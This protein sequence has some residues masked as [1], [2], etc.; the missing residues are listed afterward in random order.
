MK[1]LIGKIKGTDYK[2]LMIQHG[3]KI[4]LGL[5]VLVAVLVCARGYWFGYDKQP[6]ELEELAVKAKATIENSVFPEEE[7]NKFQASTYYAKAEQMLRPLEGVPYLY[8]TQFT[9]S[10]RPR[11]ERNKEPEFSTVEHLIAAYGK[12]LM[13]SNEPAPVAEETEEMSEDA[14]EAG[15]ETSRRDTT[16]RRGS[17]TAG[18]AMGSGPTAAMRSGRMPPPGEITISGISGEG[19]QSAEEVKPNVEGRQFISVRGVFPLNKQAQRYMRALHTDNLL[20][21]ADLVEIVD[22]K[23]QRQKIVPGDKP[24]SGPWE[25]L[26]YTTSI[27]VLDAAGDIDDD[28]VDSGVLDNTISMPLPLRLLGFWTDTLASHP[29]LKN[30]ELSKEEIEEERKRN[31]MYM[32]QYNNMEDAGADDPRAKRGFASRMVDIRGIRNAV[33]QNPE[34]SRAMYSGA[35]SAGGRRPQMPQSSTMPMPAPVAI[36]PAGGGGH[37]G[38]GARP[39]GGMRNMGMGAM[40]AMAGGQSAAEAR[41]AAAGRLLLFRYLDFDVE[42][43]EAYRYRVR[44]EFANPNYELALDQVE[45]EDIAEGKTRW[46]DWSEPCQAVVVEKEYDFFLTDVDRGRGRALP[47]AR[48]A[49]FQWLRDVGSYINTTA[50]QPLVVGVGAYVGGKGKSTLLEPAIPS[51]K[52]DQTVSFTSKD[53][54]VDVAPSPQVLIGEHPDLQLTSK[55]ATR[56]VRV[57]PDEAVVVNQFGEMVTIDDLSGRKQEKKAEAMVDRERKDFEDLLDSEKAEGS[58]LDR[59]TQMMSSEQP[60]NKKKKKDKSPLMRGGPGSMMP[61][62]PP[63]AA[64]AGSG[65]KPRR[66]GS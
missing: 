20:E 21:A 11:L 45:R 7:K 43:G 42:P 66:G 40:G 51:M 59:M 31:E 16:A 37:G 2:G 44:L 61:P 46:S 48:L 15:D 32:A 9:W 1:N 34:A 25:D 19:M 65:R 4:A 3:E 23:I 27:E 8:G 30:F 52:K 5:A 64:P 14:S 54:L 63:G 35:G 56:P 49:M 10:L 47:S 28:V 41:I 33:N 58:E 22:F 50:V 12:A 60:D 6:K 29:D 57:V 26:D 18:G 36:M 24:F 62:A 17:G 39:P 38:G 13:P 53:V 55:V